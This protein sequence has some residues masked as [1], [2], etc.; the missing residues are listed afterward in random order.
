[1]PSGA[2]STGRWTRPSRRSACIHRRPRC[3]A[4]GTGIQM[5]GMNSGLSDTNPTIV[6]AFKS[7]LLHQ[8]LIVAGLLLLLGLAWLAMREWLP[9][10]RGAAAAGKIAASAEPA[11]RRLQRSGF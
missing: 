11:R 6:A 2:R 8:G 1:M 7:A 3:R 4:D 10:A 9:S 5:P